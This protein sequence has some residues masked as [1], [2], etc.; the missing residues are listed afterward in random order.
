[1]RRLF[2][3]LII[4]LTSF[5]ANGQVCTKTLLIKSDTVF[6]DPDKVAHPEEGRELYFGLDFK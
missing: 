6:I 4:S 5:A 1:M 2:T 3:V